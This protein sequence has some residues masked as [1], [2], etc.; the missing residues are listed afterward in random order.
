MKRRL[1]LL[2]AALTF[3]SAISS[4]KT[5]AYDQTSVQSAVL[6]GPQ[7]VNP[8]TVVKDNRAEILRTYLEQYNSPLAE[9]AETFIQQADANHLDCKMVA[10]ISGV[11]STYVEAVPQYSY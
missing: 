7:A 4:Q 5:L 8:Q 2:L 11:E 6:A 10:A 1:V 3:F 9:H